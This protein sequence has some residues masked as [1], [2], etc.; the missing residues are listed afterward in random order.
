M[1]IKPPKIYKMWEVS[2]FLSL[3]LS[4]F[5]GLLD[6]F[7][8]TCEI[9][10]EKFYFIEVYLLPSAHIRWA[11]LATSFI[12][13]GTIEPTYVHMRKQMTWGIDA[14]RI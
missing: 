4:F 6:I 1:F 10:L 3:S 13:G 14:L 8:N 11:G 2:F 5:F 7:P 12:Y 9:L